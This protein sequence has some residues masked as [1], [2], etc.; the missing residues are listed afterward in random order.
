MASGGHIERL[1]RAETLF[2]R[3]AI[4]KREP[5][6]YIALKNR[7]AVGMRVHY[8]LLVCCVVDSEHAYLV[9]FEFNLVMFK[10][11]E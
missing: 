5:A 9:I 6:V 1:A 7:D 2:F 10:E 11:K 8:R 4:R 3:F